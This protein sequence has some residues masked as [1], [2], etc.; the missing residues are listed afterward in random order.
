MA[1]ASADAANRKP[2]RSAEDWV[3]AAFKVLATSSIEAVKVERLAKD[4]GVTKGSFYWHFADR[5][6]LLAAMREAWVAMGTEQVIAFV[7]QQASADPRQALRALID[8]TLAPSD[9]FDGVEGA[10]REWSAH[11]PETAAVCAAVDERRLHYVIDLLTGAGVSDGDADARA[12]VLYRILIGDYVF[13][14]HGGTP[15]DTDAVKAVGD[16]FFD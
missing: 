3:L 7:D 10:I 16:R 6:A 1:P 13:R 8:V 11:D 5:P 15:V 9:D 14:R 2:R 4:L 12:G